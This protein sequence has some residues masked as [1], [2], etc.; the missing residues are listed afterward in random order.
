MPVKMRGTKKPVEWLRAVLNLK[1]Q[2][3][4]SKATPKRIIVLD[5]DV[6]VLTAI[7][8]VL[9]LSGFDAEIFDTVAGFLDGA[10][11]DEAFCLVLDINLDGCSGI[12]L[13]KH[14]ANTGVSV[15][16]IF[17]TATDSK[18]IRAAALQAGCVSFLHKPFPSRDLIEAIEQIA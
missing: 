16:V 5:D 4:F 2:A 18:A 8:R 9:R 6:S 12:E 14:L 7:E 3:M 11:F 17:I 15:P 1:R 10:R 13:R